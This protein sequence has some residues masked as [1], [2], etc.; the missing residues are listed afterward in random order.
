MILDSMIDVVL[1]EAVIVGPGL[2][3][4][5]Q[6]CF[7]SGSNV[8]GACFGRLE[9]QSITLPTFIPFCEL[10]PGSGFFWYPAKFRLICLH[11]IFRDGVISV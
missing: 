6:Q 4:L 3:M 2:F 11:F 9:P 10:I 7:S 8:A 5:W 1:W